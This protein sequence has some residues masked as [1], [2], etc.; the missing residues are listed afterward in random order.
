M[1]L[2]FGAR[3]LVLTLGFALAALLGSAAAEAQ[4]PPAP[5]QTTSPPADESALGE[6][7]VT[8]H[9]TD[10]LPR[11]AIL[12][13]LSAD[14]EDVIVRSVVRRDIELTGLF[15]L[16]P[17]S[18]APVGLYSFDEPVDV[19]EWQK[20][21]AEAIVKVAARPKGK[22]A[23]VYGLAYFLNVGKEPVYSKKI[24]VDKADV[25]V[26]AHR[27][28]DALLGALTGRPGGFASQ[29]AFAAR[30]TKNQRVFRLDA[31]GQSLTPLT[32]AA[33]FAIAPMWGPNGSLYFSSS[34][35]FSPFGLFQLANGS[36]KPVTLP[37]KTSVYGVAF[38]KDYTK[39]AVAVAEGGKSTIYVGLADGTGMTKASTTELATHPVFS[40]TGKLAWI[41]GDAAHGSTR[42][43]VDG[44]AVSPSGFGA[45]APTFC[46]TEDGVRLVYSVGVGNDRRDLV[47]SDDQGRGMSRLT[48]GQGSN[49]FPACSPDGRLLAFFSTRKEQPGIYMM[50]L[51]RFTTQLLTS[52][53]GESLRWAAL[54][55][56]K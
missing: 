54:P 4:S 36:I 25:R 5:T 28:T 43:Y 39:M 23:E 3:K 38:N 13:S 1:R 14:L 31:D 44:K 16:I 46:D 18:K 6:L 22:Q 52:K 7:L 15:E 9:K 45:S 40:P 27:I 42:V 33:D 32:E 37:F 24:T 50:S 49:T 29:L 12:P 47:M 55:P 11:I 21:G 48:Q 53:I 41:G 26:T 19:P 35:D 56:A 51:K 34:H 8:G 2:T 17:D 30:W 10:K 20:L